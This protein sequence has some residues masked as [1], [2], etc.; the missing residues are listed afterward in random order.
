MNFMKRG[1]IC[2]LLLSSLLL[3]CNT[4]NPKIEGVI[5][6]DL[7]SYNIATIWLDPNDKLGAK[8]L[9]PIMS[10]WTI[11]ERKENDKDSL[12]L[13]FNNHDTKAT[14]KDI[15]LVIIKKEPF[16]NSQEALLK[17]AESI[18]NTSKVKYEYKIKDFTGFS[19]ET[20]NS[21]PAIEYSY[22]RATLFEPDKKTLLYSKLFVASEKPS[23]RYGPIIVS[24]SAFALSDE[25]LEQVKQ[26]NIPVFRD[27]FNAIEFRDFE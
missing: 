13:F 24:Y 18:F 4:L 14:A 21:K 20:V 3:G 19:S 27:S 10:D 7:G 16:Q 15:V 25:M 6:E 8:I 5:I 9:L 11:K 1:L 22:S 12:L 2:S 26:R 17:R 23:K